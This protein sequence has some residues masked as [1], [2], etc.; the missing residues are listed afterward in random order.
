MESFNFFS[1]VDKYTHA[2][3]TLYGTQILEK[4]IN[5]IEALVQNNVN[6]GKKMKKAVFVQDAERAEVKS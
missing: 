6:S 4:A 1:M 5:T 3:K 2:G